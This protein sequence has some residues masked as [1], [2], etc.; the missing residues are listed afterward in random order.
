MPFDDSSILHATFFDKTALF[1]SVQRANETYPFKYSVKHVVILFLRLALLS[2]KGSNAVNV[3]FTKE[4][5]GNC[6]GLQA[7]ESRAVR[8]ISLPLSRVDGT[9]A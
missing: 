9:G 6:S 1:P 5:N 4:R 2:L 3:K 8:G 7:A